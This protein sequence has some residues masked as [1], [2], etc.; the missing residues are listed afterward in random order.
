MWARSHPVETARGKLKSQYGE[1]AYPV[2]P[3]FLKIQKQRPEK[4]RSLL[5]SYYFRNYFDTT[6]MNI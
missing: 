2:L 5:Y 1:K 3:P 4:L 6:G